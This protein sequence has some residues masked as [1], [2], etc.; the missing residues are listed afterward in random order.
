MFFYLTVFALLLT[1]VLS[2]LFI[3]TGMFGE[4]EQNGFAFIISM[5]VFN[6]IY[7]NEMKWQL[8]DKF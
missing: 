3:I 2:V 4:L 1:V 5:Q 7:Y 8:I 6:N